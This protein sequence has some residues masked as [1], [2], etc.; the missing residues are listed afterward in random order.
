VAFPPIG[1]LL[2]TEAVVGLRLGVVQAEWV[3][4]GFR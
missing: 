3:L 1:P 2:A 4:V